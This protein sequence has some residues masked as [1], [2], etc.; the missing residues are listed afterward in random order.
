MLSLRSSPR[1]PYSL[2]FHKASL[3]APA[4][5]IYQ[6]RLFHGKVRKS[7]MEK[8]SFF[9]HRERS[10]PAVP[11]RFL[12]SFFSS[13]NDDCRLGARDSIRRFS[14]HVEITKCL[15]I[16]RF[17]GNVRILWSILACDLLFY[18]EV[19]GIMLTTQRAF[20]FFFFFFYPFV[21]LCSFNLTRVHSI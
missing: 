11:L 19:N 18:S 2:P 8:A 16:S 6:M 1:F 4:T 21:R 7:E 15:R 17:M 12:Y 5:L 3:S 14:G 13:A 9:L 10:I 20:F